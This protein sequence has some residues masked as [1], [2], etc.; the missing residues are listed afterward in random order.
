M[1]ERK[2]TDKK[3]PS[4]P[5]PFLMAVSVIRGVNLMSREGNSRQALSLRPPRLISS[6]GSP[7]FKK[8]HMMSPNWPEA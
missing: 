7:S 6:S 3:L 2:T 4:L 1:K 8:E 5:W